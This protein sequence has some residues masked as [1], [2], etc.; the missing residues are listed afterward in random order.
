MPCLKPAVSAGRSHLLVSRDGQ[1]WYAG[2]MSRASGAQRR[3][4]EA[5]R[6][7]ALDR[8]GALEREFAGIVEAARQANADDEHDP[9]GATIA[10]ERQHT[11]ALLSQARRR[12]EQ[13]D[14]AVQRVAAGRYGVCERCGEPIDPD[15]LAARPTAVR[16]IGCAT[17]RR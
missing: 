15:R 16:C 4:L 6:Q 7:A 9:E 10:F 13:V 8:V 5:E 11:A 2:V 12:L 17:G 3:L 1:G 14:Q